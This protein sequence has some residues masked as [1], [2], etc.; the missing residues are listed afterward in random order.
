MF[1]GEEQAQVVLWQ[2]DFGNFGEDVGLV[3]ADPIDLW[4]GETREHDVAR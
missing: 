2:Q 4:G 1:A 3:F